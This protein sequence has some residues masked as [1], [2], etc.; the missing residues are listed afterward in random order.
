MPG[1]RRAAEPEQAPVE[2]SS[3][4]PAPVEPGAQNGERRT[5]YIVF[6]SSSEEGPWELLKEVPARS[7]DEA[8]KLA[9]DGQQDDP[10]FMSQYFIAISA[11]SFKPKKPTVKTTTAVSF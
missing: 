2:E 4:A 7:Q 6:V 3:E 10:S 8:R 9:V 1:R 5:K 11:S